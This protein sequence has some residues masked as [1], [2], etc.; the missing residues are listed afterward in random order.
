MEEASALVPKVLK[1]PALLAPSSPLPPYLGPGRAAPEGLA[2]VAWEAIGEVHDSDPN[3][4]VKA[5]HERPSGRGLFRYRGSCIQPRF[6]SS[7]GRV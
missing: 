3:R 4:L 5:W 7:Q 1:K 2:E 6:S